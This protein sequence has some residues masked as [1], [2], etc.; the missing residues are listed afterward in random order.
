MFS[1]T[2]IPS[3]TKHGHRAEFK[4]LILEEYHQFSAYEYLSG[5]VYERSFANELY[6]ILT[7]HV[8]CWIHQH[9]QHQHVDE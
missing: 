7:K 3:H 5:T 2:M 6:E 1:S 9:H 4:R 8:G